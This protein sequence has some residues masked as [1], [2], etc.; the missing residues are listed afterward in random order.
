MSNYI[1]DNAFTQY[2]EEVESLFLNKETFSLDELPIF[3]STDSSSENDN[4]DITT[5]KNILRI[6]S[7]FIKLVIIQI[8]YLFS[9]FLI[10]TFNSH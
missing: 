8:F 2:K 6:V 7:R 1:Y 3:E 10:Y 4:K 5:P 9:Y